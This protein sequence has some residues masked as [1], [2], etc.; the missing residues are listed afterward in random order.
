[1]VNYSTHD[2]DT[3]RATAAQLNCFRG[4]TCACSVRKSWYVRRS[5]AALAL[6]S[7]SCTSVAT[8]PKPRPRG[9]YSC[10]SIAYS[11]TYRRTVLTYR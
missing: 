10:Y 7:H 5:Q 3:R 1:M 9:C 4:H 6:T 11:F 8:A 2:G